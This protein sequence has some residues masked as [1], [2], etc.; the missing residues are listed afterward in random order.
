MDKGQDTLSPRNLPELD[1]TNPAGQISGLHAG[2][3]VQVATWHGRLQ[4]VSVDG[5]L[6][7][8][9][10][11]VV[12]RPMHAL[13]VAMLGAA[14]LCLTA[15][16]GVVPLLRRRGAGKRLIKA[17]RWVLGGLGAGLL[18]EGVGRLKR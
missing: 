14:G 15:L 5:Q 17:A 9:D 7:Y 16:L 11:S 13:A 12:Q 1:F 18:V 3:Q 10:E 4:A 8:A 2:E 6:Y